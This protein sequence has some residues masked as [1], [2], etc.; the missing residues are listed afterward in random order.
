MSHY[1]DNNNYYSMITINII[2]LCSNLLNGGAV[3]YR[4]RST[5]WAWCSQHNWCNYSSVKYQAIS[6]NSS[7]EILRLA[8]R[9]WVRLNVSDTTLP[10]GRLLKYFCLW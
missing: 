9:I 1:Y 5:F 6:E 10:R 7:R 2:A 3:V 4:R 8:T